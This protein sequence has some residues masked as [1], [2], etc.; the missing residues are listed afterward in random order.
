MSISTPKLVQPKLIPF[1]NAPEDNQVLSSLQNRILEDF[2][3]S[4]AMDFIEKGIKEDDIADAVRVYYLQK[5]QQK[6]LA[7]FVTN[8]LPEEYKI[9]GN[10][11]DMW[12]FTDNKGKD[13]FR[14][15]RT[16]DGTID[17][18]LDEE[19]S[20][21]LAAKK[22]LQV[23]YEHANRYKDLDF[24]QAFYHLY[25]KNRTIALASNPTIH[26]SFDPQRQEITK[27][28]TSQSSTFETYFLKA[29]PLEFLVA[30][31]WL[32]VKA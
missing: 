13:I 5:S 28:D 4:I 24:G 32:V 26:Y 15:Y 23:F 19:T 9:N 2:N 18:W 22:F 27:K 8:E 31:D 17:V 3:A 25:C 10:T 14:L 20:Y 16:L 30:K 21:T 11:P 7:D 12:V 29:I 6:V 1:E